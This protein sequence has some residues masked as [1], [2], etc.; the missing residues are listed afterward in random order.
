M[1]AVLVVFNIIAVKGVWNMFRKYSESSRN[2]SVAEAEKN[3]LMER[4]EALSDKLGR[5]S[6]DSGMDE[7]IRR[8]FGVA[9]EGE[10]VIVIVD[11]QKAQVSEAVKEY[12]WWQKL[13]GFVSGIFR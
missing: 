2:L 9:K 8:R 3:E 6:S 10:K 7:E 12:G 11:E 1:V 5:L 4:K 13:T